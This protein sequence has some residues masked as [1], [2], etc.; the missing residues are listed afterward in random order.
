MKVGSF[1]PNPWGLYDMHGNVWE[2][3]SDWYA[4]YPSEMVADPKGP[5]SG[6]LKIIRGGSW[7]FGST[8]ARSAFRKTHE[9]ELWGFSIGFRIVREQDHPANKKYHCSP[10]KKMFI[11]Y[12]KFLFSDLL[13]LQNFI[14]YVEFAVGDKSI[15]I[16]E[17]D[18]PVIYLFLILYSEYQ[19]V[20]PDPKGS[21]LIVLLPLGWGKQGQSICGLGNE[22]DTH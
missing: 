16:K 19:F 3:V 4:P 10:D 6:T 2:W 7:Y 21:E 13:V 1:A 5:E 12:G 9:P 14:H 20:Y 11:P 18:Y 8:N 22:T 15:V 17:Y